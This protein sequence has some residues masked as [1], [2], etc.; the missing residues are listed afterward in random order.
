M[1]PTRDFNRTSELTSSSRYGRIR[2]LDDDE[3]EDD[4]KDIP[5]RTNRESKA[6][7]DPNLLRSRESSDEV[8][9]NEAKVTSKADLLLER[10][11]SAKRS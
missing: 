9:E 3:I 2:E 6:N 7:R 10:L 1:K 4:D 11:G 5:P 8:T